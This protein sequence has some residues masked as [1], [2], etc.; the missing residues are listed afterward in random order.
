MR[1]RPF[2]SLTMRMWASGRLSQPAKP[3]SAALHSVAIA[4]SSPVGGV[5]P[6]VTRTEQITVARAP[7]AADPTV[8]AATFAVGW[9][10]LTTLS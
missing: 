4:P 10:D 7:P 5:W 6:D 2:L 1:G 9:L 3:A 8:A